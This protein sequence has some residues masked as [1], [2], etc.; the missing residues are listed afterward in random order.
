MVNSDFKSDLIRHHYIFTKVVR[1]TTQLIRN[2]LL[3]SCYPEL[4]VR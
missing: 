2:C 3:S 4:S 1:R